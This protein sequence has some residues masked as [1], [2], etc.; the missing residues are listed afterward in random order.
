M[1]G[2]DWVH[3]LDF[4]INVCMCIANLLICSKADPPPLRAKSRHS[5]I[6]FEHQGAIRVAPPIMVY[7][8]A[9]TKL[10]LTRS[11]GAASRMAAARKPPY[12]K[13]VKVHP[14]YI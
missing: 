9:A 8:K 11:Q 14:L 4:V 12:L 13:Q 7:N 5:T 10:I 6:K 2:I 3:D 1:V